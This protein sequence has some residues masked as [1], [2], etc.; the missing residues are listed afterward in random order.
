MHGYYKDMVLK[1][2]SIILYIGTT[3]YL[4]LVIIVNRYVSQPY[5]ECDFSI[6]AKSLLC[7]VIDFLGNVLLGGA[8]YVNIVTVRTRIVGGDCLLP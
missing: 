4:G 2:I 3:P 8:G 7:Y 5:L 6:G 1:K